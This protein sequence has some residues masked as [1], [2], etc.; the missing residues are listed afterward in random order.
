MKILYA[1]LSIILLSFVIVQYNDP[2][3]FLWI[4]IYGYGAV[5]L[6]LA[7]WGIYHKWA[8]LTGII[9]YAIGIIYLFPS[10]IEWMEKEHGNNLMQR[11]ANSKMYIEETRECG[12]LIIAMIFLL[13]SFI[14]H[15]RNRN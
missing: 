2:D 6:A 14:Q 8:T 1:I 13:F 7:A 12:G 9:G 11:M 10:V 4:P 3:P 5:I 15:R